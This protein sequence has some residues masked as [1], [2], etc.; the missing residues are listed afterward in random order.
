MKAAISELALKRDKAIEAKQKLL[1]SA[2]TSL[3][4]S[5]SLVLSAESKNPE[6]LRLLMDTGR[7]LCDVQYG[8][9]STRRAFILSALKKDMKEQIQSTKVDEL[10][11]GQNLSETLKAAKTVN[12]SGA[13]LRPQAAPKPAANRPMTSTANQKNWKGPVSNR[14]QYRP[15]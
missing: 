13:D 11:F 9:S 10:L 15:P 12:K 4:E 14:Q 2:I 1:S 3:G 7:I 6:L 8:D 5:I